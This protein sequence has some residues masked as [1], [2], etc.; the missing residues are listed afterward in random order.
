M[1]TFSLLVWL[2]LLAS[3]YADIPATIPGNEPNIVIH[4]QR[5][6]SP[7]GNLM[8]PRVVVP[9]GD[10]GV[11]RTIAAGDIDSD[12]IRDLI[13]ATSDGSLKLFHGKVSPIVQGGG[14]E[15]RPEFASVFDPIDSTITLGM[16]PDILDVGDFNADGKQDILAGA[17]GD[18]RLFLLVGDGAGHFSEI[19]TIAIP[20]QITAAASGEIGQPDG[21]TDV[22]VAYTRQSRSYLAVFEHPEG[23]FSH[24]AETFRLAAKAAVVTLGNLNNDNFG[25]IAVSS[26]DTVTVIFERGQVYPWDLDRKSGIMRP[27]AVISTRVLPFQISDIAAADLAGEDGDEIALLSADGGLYILEPSKSEA[28]QSQRSVSAGTTKAIPFAPKGV[29]ATQLRLTKRDMN[30]KDIVDRSGIAL[31]D[32]RVSAR[33]NT[34]ETKERRRNSIARPSEERSD[35][36]S[37]DAKA[38][39]VRSISA[40]PSNP[41]TWRLTQPNPPVRFALAANSAVRNKLIRARIGDSPHDG[42]IIADPSGAQIHVLRS[43]D[44]H[45]DTFDVASLQ[46]EG[47]PDAVLPMRLNRDSLDDLVILQ[48]DGTLSV[49]LSTPTATFTVNT[50][51]DGSSNCVTAGQPCTLREAIQLANANPGMDTIAFSI[52][53]CGPHKISPSSEL[54]PITGAISIQGSSQPC[55]AGTPLIEINGSLITNQAADGLKLRTSNS[56]IQGIAVN[57]FPAVSDGESLTGGNGITVENT[58]STTTN[59]NNTIWFNYLGVDPNGTTARGNAA[60]GIN[61]YSSH[62]NLI[63]GNTISGNAGAGI[64]VTAGNNNTIISNK[65]GTT[66]SGNGK[67]PNAYWGIFLTGNNNSVG[68]DTAG[69]GNTISGNGHPRSAPNQA[70]C[71]GT[72]ISIFALY[73]ADNTQLLT[74]GNNLKGNRI[75]TN[76]AGTAPLGNCAAGIE[77]D[78]ITTTTIGSISDNGRNIV[79]DNG[80]DAIHCGSPFASPS[81]GGFCKIVGNNIGTDVTGTVAIS[82]DWRNVPDG[83]VPVSSV[84]HVY[85][86]DT[87]SNIGAPGGTTANGACTGF[88]NLISGN[89][90]AQTGADGAVGRTGFGSVG[91]FNNFIGVDRN[92]T[93]ALG[94]TLTGIDAWNND[95]YIG[96]YDLSTNTNFGNVVSGNSFAAVEVLQ[97]SIFFTSTFDIEANLIGTD[98]TG[99]ATIPNGDGSHGALSILAYPNMTVTVGGTDPS[100]KNYIAGNDTNGIWVRGLGGSAQVI[101]NYIGFSKFNQPLG[102]TKHGVLLEGSGTVVGGTLPTQQNV[103]YNNTLAGVAVHDISTSGISSINNSIRGNSIRNNGGLGIDLTIESTPDGDGVTPNDCSDNDEGANHRQNFPELFDPT[104]NQDG[105]VTVS[106]FLKTQPGAGDYK[107]DFY[108][109]TAADQSDY[110]EG[111]TYIGTQTVQLNGNGSAPL[112]FTSSAQVSADKKITATA[113]D[114]AGNTS[115]FSCYAGGCQQTTTPQSKA[116]QLEAA[117]EAH[118][119]EPIVVNID[120]DEPDSDGDQP[121]PNLRDGKCDVDPSKDG[122]QCSLR[123]AIQEAN[124]RP[125]RDFIFFKIDGP[126][127]HT[128]APTQA[129]PLITDVVWVDATTQPGYSGTPLIE[130][131]GSGVSTTDAAGLDFAPG[132]GVEHEIPFE[133]EGSVVT[134]MAI[135]KWSGSAIHAQGSPSLQ[136]KKCFIGINSDG[137]TADTSRRSK[138]GIFLENSVAE[139][140]GSLERDGNVISNND[141]GITSNDSIII[142]GNKVGSDVTGTLALPNRFGIDLTPL[143]DSDRGSTSKILDNLISGNTLTAIETLRS[144]VEITNNLIGT[145]A[146][147]NA[148]LAIGAYGVVA[149]AGFTVIRNNTIAGFADPSSNGSA[150]LV[151]GGDR[152]FVV[153]NKIGVRSDGTGNLPNTIGVRLV[154]SSNSEIIEDGFVSPA[155]PG[156]IIANSS[157]EGI[158]ITCHIDACSGNKIRNNVIKNNGVLDSVGLQNDG[159]LLQGLISG[160]DIIDNTIADNGRNGVSFEPEPAQVDGQSTGAT[161]RGNTIAGNGAVGLLLVQ[162]SSNMVQNNTVNGNKIGI[163]MIR[164]SNSN[165]IESNELASNH[166]IDL[167]LGNST[168]SFPTG[169]GSALRPTTPAETCPDTEISQNNTIKGNLIKNSQVGIAVTECARNNTIGDADRNLPN[170][171]TGNQSGP[172]YGMFLGTTT[173]N[174]TQDAMPSDN[175]ILGNLFGQDATS[176]PN[177]VGLLVSQAINNQVGMDDLSGNIFVANTEGGLILSGS[178]TTGN[179][180]ANNFIG[181]GV[182]DSLLDH[183]FGN[184]G[185]GIAILATGVNTVKN[186]RIGNNRGNGINVFGVGLQSDDN[187]ILISGNEVGVAGNAPIG[188]TGAGI[189]LNN[190][191]HA[192]VGVGGQPKNIVAANGGD[193]ILIE[194]DSSKLNTITNTVI[195]TSQNGAN[196]LANAGNGIHIIGGS[197]NTI[198][199]VPAEG[200]LI[201]GNTGNGV[202]VE[203]STVNAFYGNRIGI[204][205]TDQG[206]IKLANGQNGMKFVNSSNNK[207]GDGVLSLYRNFIGGSGVSGIVLSGAASQ[208]DLVKGNYIGTDLANANL[209]NTL[210][211]VHITDQGQHNVIGGPEVEAGN[212]IAFNGLVGNA[213]DGVFIDPTALCC[214]LVDPNSIFGNAG[215]GI[216]LGQPG[217]T[218]NDLHDADEGPNRLQNFP[219]IV[220]R[221]IVNNELILTF[222][223]DSAPQYSNYGPNGLY[224]EFFKAANGSQGETFIGSTYYTQADYDAG[225]PGTKTIDLGSLATLGIAANDPV[226]ATASDAD[227]NTSEFSLAQAPTAAGVS[228]G[229]RILDH[230][231]R[232]IR[233]ALVTLTDQQGREVSVYSSLSGYYRF[234]SVQSGQFVVLGVSSRRYQ[235]LAKV[236]AVRDTLQEVDLVAEN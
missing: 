116:A 3:Q 212:H 162:S 53:G 182:D 221:Q 137:V 45:T 27:A 208:N 50:T 109:N 11:S 70:L 26:R 164:A 210:Y 42:I 220:S 219:T 86:N 102:N 113:T 65:I 209:G 9:G 100:S 4:S 31:I 224:V 41:S 151:L 160:I 2:Q 124:A 127:V 159:L 223:V 61:I 57:Q 146:N 153:G 126:G 138:T 140:G 28:E 92:G 202:M 176:S 82:N 96:G 83:D 150:A 231:G 148:I 166:D 233:N 214:N 229:G 170:T 103:I 71:D 32:P 10:V 22:A 152:H 69:T 7:T 154:N 36:P 200:N 143:S 133:L 62:N 34:A 225:Q 73:S 23:A 215:L 89:N 179:L 149:P 76:S 15:N 98:T 171:F 135:N 187:S 226:S 217:T 216:D 163:R 51:S 125:D 136:V 134:G 95:T 72:G 222:S 74:N 77:T 16:V 230:S 52:L 79:S 12:G 128:I 123:A 185:D 1:I 194:G 20:G 180:V 192:L 193:G 114:P 97:G 18:T 172:G 60:T 33:S 165:R 227:G 56:F 30:D 131:S 112:D 108:A 178:P 119:T 66:A 177:K 6:D 111:E 205:P 87:L 105:T 115:E 168:P 195:G 228:V 197:Q 145:S 29:D 63:Q 129:L 207:V 81:S 199:G 117:Q 59:N 218:P 184:G 174:P 186:N 85:N 196:F 189:R 37:V 17:T 55:S 19:R 232:G 141:V 47:G 132:S 104:F 93:A 49:S 14:D 107:I 35:E 206:N 40:S 90:S 106:G 118:C 38:A 44:A 25:D 144:S 101:N 91:I 157:Y 78:P 99:G 234:D 142:V 8:D 88:C 198:G 201:S 156:N 191:R 204:F 155:G 39:F 175:K 173:D 167:L 43:L 183:A 94:N 84:V 46:L 181:V 21:Q 130:L 67:L 58:T 120:T 110:G 139:V 147:G 235:F 211:G 80:Y 169:S 158:I 75:G 13:I 161:I 203:N 54:P 213:G 48:Q 122:N 64:S 188:N 68:M 24:E 5:P 236:V 190:V 121:D